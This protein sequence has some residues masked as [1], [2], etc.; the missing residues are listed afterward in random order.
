MKSPKYVTWKNF[1]VI[2]DY[3]YKS[4]R[5]RYRRNTPN[6]DY[7]W[8][9][10]GMSVNSTAASFSISVL[11]VACVNMQSD[12]VM[13]EDRVVICFGRTWHYIWKKQ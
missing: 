7:F 13:G 3:F 8:G 4:R 10:V 2:T 1:T 12:R 6:F 11:V 5:R 9:N